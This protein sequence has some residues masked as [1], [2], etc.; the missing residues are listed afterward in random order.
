MKKV[1]IVI[2]ILIL[3]IWGFLF[4]MGK[5]KVESP[6]SIGNDQTGITDQQAA[7]VVPKNPATVKNGVQEFTISGQSFFFT[8]NVINVKKGDKVRIIF[9]N[10]S[11]LHDFKI[12]EFGVAS[13]QVKSP[14]Q[15][16]LEFTADKTGSFQY[17]CSVGSHRA[18]GM[19]GTLNVQ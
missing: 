12:D 17:Y 19:F 10:V 5:N 2:I 1:S 14:Y 18:M 4:F 9:E 15:E 3:V 8:P 7:P 11:G 13:K 16:I 6:S